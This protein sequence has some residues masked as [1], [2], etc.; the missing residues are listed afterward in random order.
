MIE[1]VDAVD[2]GRARPRAQDESAASFQGLLTDELAR[3]EWARA[4]AELD[5]L[6]RGCDPSPGAWALRGDDVVRLFDG[7][8]L[9]GDPGASAG[10][11]LGF[12]EGRLLVAVRGG[13]L[14]IGKLRVGEGAKVAAAEARLEAGERLR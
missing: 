6:V 3:V 11:V 7:R 9:P 1:A 2:R 10:E 14:S 5:R 13:R 12:A 8:W 4:G